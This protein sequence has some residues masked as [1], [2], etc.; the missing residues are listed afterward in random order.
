M[1]SETAAYQST[2]PPV[3]VRHLIAL[4]VVLAYLV[5]AICV[6]VAVYL[7][8]IVRSGTSIPLHAAESVVALACIYIALGATSF[9]VWVLYIAGFIIF[10]QLRGYADDTGMPVQY[11][12]PIVM[13]RALFL[14]QI[15][16]IWLQERLYTFTRLGPVEFY[17][18]VV[19]LAYFFVPHIMAF[20][21]WR[22]DR[23]RFK[24][25]V[26][27][28]MGTIYIGL[29]ACAVLPTAPPWL[30]GQVGDIPHVYQ[31][32]TDI[33]GTVTPGTYENVYEVAGANPVA[34]MPSLHS[35]VPFLMAI[36]LW[37]YRY[38]R[39]LGAAY[40]GSMAFSVVYLGEHY[41][42]DAF[43]GWGVAGLT[44]AGA[45]AYVNRSESSR[46]VNAGATAG[47][48]KV[49]EKAPPV[50]AGDTVV[51]TALGA[52]L[53]CNDGQDVPILASESISPAHT[54]EGS[55]PPRGR[56]PEAQ[57]TGRQ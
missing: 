1:S 14:G 27:A 8:A 32:V 5:R 25:Y 48:P 24:T 19:Y 56:Q 52:T 12:Y 3:V 13:E 29:V 42:V 55:T 26:L 22:W 16:S 51:N 11:E 23:Q 39:W 9:R 17:T 54:A 57:G 49:T 35:A 30:A 21:L 53:P 45:R 46:M 10:A 40:A 50:T 38:V 34:A 31:I 6:I 44:W 41:A 15:P 4:R 20:A 2:L 36:A 47:R 43:V 7:L 33:S 37:K 18:M 28:F